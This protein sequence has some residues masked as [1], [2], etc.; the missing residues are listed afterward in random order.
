MSSV[1]AM[2]CFPCFPIS[3]G[4]GWATTGSTR[5]LDERLEVR[6]PAIGCR[7]RLTASAAWALEAAQSC[8]PGTSRRRPRDPC[9]GQTADRTRGTGPSRPIGQIIGLEPPGSTGA[10]HP[11][12]RR[13]RGRV[14]RGQFGCDLGLNTSRTRRPRRRCG[15]PA[16]HMTP[17]RLTLLLTNRT[18]PSHKRV[19]PAGVVSP[20]R[21]TPHRQRSTPSA[22]SE[23]SVQNPNGYYASWAPG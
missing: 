18:L 7:P 21:S 9:S 17:V 13:R 1:N 6:R 19:G 8:R 11:R 3:G 15:R 16:A 5:P 2:P 12:R 22:P 10:G 20:A 4:P 23:F 14:R